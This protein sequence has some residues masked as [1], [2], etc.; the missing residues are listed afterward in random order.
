MSQSLYKYLNKLENHS[1]LVLGGSSGI[2]FAV[3]EAALEHGARVVISSSNQAKVDSAVLQLQ[4]HAKAINRSPS[5]VTGL[6]CDLANGTTVEDNIVKLLEFATKVDK[7][8]HVAYT[9][10]NVIG[11]P[12]L[13]RTTLQE[14]HGASM[15]RQY[16]P[17]LLA[18]QLPKYMKVSARG[19]F[20]ITGSTNAW[21]PGPGWSV[22]TSIV[23]G[24]EGLARGLAVDLNPLR[25]NVVQLGIVPTEFFDHIPHRQEF[26]EQSRRDVLT[27]RLGKP[28]EV[29]EA[30]IYL[31]KDSFATGTTLVT[32]GGA[33]ISRRA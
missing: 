25:V 11:L 16:A 7:L 26:E 1:V 19:S 32:D 21:R 30:Y 8:D 5:A 28:E 27:G 13:D 17:I 20:T 3:A 22:I 29:A 15:V 6:V 18:K 10:G 24:V 12:S 9:A 31:M 4:D 23:S 2:G 33:L 14:I